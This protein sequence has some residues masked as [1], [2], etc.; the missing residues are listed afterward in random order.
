[1]HLLKTIIAGRLSPVGLVILL[2]A[3]GL[4]LSLFRRNLKLRN[5]LLVAGTFLCMPLPLLPRFG[6]CNIFPRI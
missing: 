1:M 2:F 6:P 4:G 3:G 5:A